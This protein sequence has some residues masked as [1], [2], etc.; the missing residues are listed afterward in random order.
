ME[1]KKEKVIGMDNKSNILLENRKKL[2]VSG[3]Y[4]ILGFTE[5]NILLN[6]S[7]GKLEVVGMN[8]K[9]CRL[10]LEKGEVSITGM[11]FSLNYNENIKTKKFTR[12]IL[13]KFIGKKK[14]F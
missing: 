4:E 7:L 10:D 11:I 8:L 2:I 14:W 6:T 3:A 5:D 12:N 1:L 13:S 9:V